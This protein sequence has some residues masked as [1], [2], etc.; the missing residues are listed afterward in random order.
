MLGISNRE[1]SRLNRSR[2][3]GIVR[4]LFL[5][6][7]RRMRD[8][9]RLEREKDIYYLYTYEVFADDATW[10]LKDLIAKRKQEY[11]LYQKLP[12]YSRLVFNGEIFN[13]NHASINAEKTVSSA[14]EISGIPCSNGIVE[15]EV[16]IVDS[17]QTAL[18]AKDKIL[19][20]KMTDP[21]WVFLITLAKGII[22]EKGSLLSHTAIIS[23]ELNVPSIVGVKNIT[24]IL[25][26]GDIVRMNGSTGK[27]ELVR[28]E[29]G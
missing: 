9:G 13:K 25:K 7:G 11:E 10:D 12:A 2:I 19:V 17:P 5:D 27:I 6:I 8:D 14:D 29:N 24:N 16:L 15:G 1:I 4:T 23:R 28:D 22:A 20:T 21:G 3:Y 26:T 18:R